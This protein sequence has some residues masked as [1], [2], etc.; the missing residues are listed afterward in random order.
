MATETTTNMSSVMHHGKSR[1][2]GTREPKLQANLRNIKL[3]EY[4]HKAG[5]SP[6]RKSVKK[7]C[8]ENRKRSTD[9]MLKHQRIPF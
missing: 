3:E 8:F 9:V 6:E 4:R 1:K 7:V 2:Y 5:V